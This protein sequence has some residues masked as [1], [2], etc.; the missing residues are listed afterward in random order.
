MRGQAHT[1]EAF[2]AALLVISGVAFALHAVAVTPLSA[3]TSNQHIQNQQRLMANDLLATTAKNDTLEEAILF[4]NTTWNRFQNTGDRGYY[5]NG[6][7][8]LQ[9]GRLLNRTFREDRIAF[10]VFVDFRE[11]GSRSTQ[12]LVYMGSPST[13]SVTVTRSVTVYDDTSLTAGNGTTLAA[14]NASG[15]FYAPD[16]APDAQLFN[17]MEVRMV[18][19]RM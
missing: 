19:W 10:N 17:V 4:W 1:L 16:I 2:V 8:P 7:P 15:S 12:R 9:F 14:A 6:G 13:N 18:L 5:T 3:S 11:D